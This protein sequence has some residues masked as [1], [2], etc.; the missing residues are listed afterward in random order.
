MRFYFETGPKLI[1][2]KVP[3]VR[4]QWTTERLLHGDKSYFLIEQLNPY[5]HS[6]KG[7]EVPKFENTNAEIASSK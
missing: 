2:S 1:S 7:A 6:L 3:L 5:L 4:L